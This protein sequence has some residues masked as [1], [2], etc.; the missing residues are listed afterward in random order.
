MN[1][2]TLLPMVLLGSCAMVAA[3]T[4]SAG[5]FSDD[6]AASGAAL[7]ALP[8]AAA[9][10]AATQAAAQAAAPRPGPS[11]L[12]RRGR[13]EALPHDADDVLVV[14]AHGVHGLRELDQVLEERARRLYDGRELLPELVPQ[15][16]QG[17]AHFLRE[18]RDL[19]RVRHLLVE[20][21]LLQVVDLPEDVALQGLERLGL[22]VVLVV[23]GRRAVPELADHVHGTLGAEQQRQR[24]VLVHE[25]LELVPAHLVLEH[26]PRHVVDG[27]RLLRARASDLI[28]NVRARGGQHPVDDSTSPARLHVL[29]EEV[30]AFK[31]LA[32]HTLH[33]PLLLD[34]L[35]ADD[36]RQQLEPD[37]EVLLLEVGVGVVED[38]GDAPHPVHVG[39]QK[40][41]HGV[42][43]LQGIRPHAVVVGGVNVQNYS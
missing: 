38:Q 34:P 29:R 3:A 12:R 15:R 26:A 31:V 22:L 20:T 21:D 11:G 23:A 13:A 1:R 6:V 14:V 42:V 28:H 7:P 35:P 25:P 18:L 19:G 37:G 40:H 24:A 27:Q 10:A 4:S 9:E 8:A 17:A 39:V 2:G 5:N 30:H 33:L 43:L 32:R 36:A 41:C 16:G